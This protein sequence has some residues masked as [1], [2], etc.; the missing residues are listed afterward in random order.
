MKILFAVLAL[1]GIYACTQKEK[2]TSLNQVEWLLGDWQGTYKGG[3]FYESWRKA[4]DSTMVNFIIDVNPADTVVKE[5]A[6][7]GLRNGELIHRGD[8]GSTWET[9]KLTDTEMIFKNDT[10]EYANRLIWKHSENDH[11]L[12]E[13][14]SPKGNVNYDLERVAWT[15]PVVDA[16][17]AAA[18]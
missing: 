12:A 13:I 7:I 15:G 18:R 17:I 1:G 16:F 2:I 5:S 4:N 14:Q 9:V 11:W 6:M 3:P 10:V 8:D